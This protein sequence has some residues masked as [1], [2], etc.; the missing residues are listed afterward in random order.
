V[1]DR[2]G[3]SAFRAFMIELG[4]AGTRAAAQNWSLDET[5]SRVDLARDDDM[6]DFIVPF[7][8]HLDADF[9]IRRAWEEA[10]GAVEV[11]DD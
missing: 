3:L 6:D 5:L 1:T 2:A 9:V 10:T 8:I 7:V 11:R 4:E